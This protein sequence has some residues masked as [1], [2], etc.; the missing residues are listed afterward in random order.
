MLVNKDTGIVNMKTAI[1][2]TWKSWEYCNNH[3]KS[4]SIQV[5][6]CKGEKSEKLLYL[7]VSAL[8]NK[9]EILSL[10]GGM[11]GRFSGASPSQTVNIPIHSHSS[12]KQHYTLRSH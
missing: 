10:H 11:V 3:C 5:I 6:Y 4:Y 2:A 12:V 7:K 8:E 9:I 1:C